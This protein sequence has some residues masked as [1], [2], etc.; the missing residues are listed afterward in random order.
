MEFPT[1]KK[2]EKVSFIILRCANWTLDQAT[3]GTFLQTHVK[4]TFL[5]IFI[6]L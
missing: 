2:E 5:I 1:R 3:T 6:H 4:V